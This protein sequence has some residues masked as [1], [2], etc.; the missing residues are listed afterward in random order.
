MN[1]VININI[2]GMIFHIDE[3]AFV[4]LDRYLE[5]LKQHF[6]NN[7]GGG[8]IL[9]DIEARIA[10]MLTEMIKDKGEVVS[11]ANVQQV[12]AT[13]GKPEDME[14]ADSGSGSKS[15][16][17]SWRNDYSFSPG[18]RMYRD[19]DN[20]IIGGVC[21]GMGEYLGIDPVWL[22]L[23]FCALFFGFGTG[24]LIYIILWI[25]LPAANTPSEKLEMR[26]ERVNISNIEKTVTENLDALKQRIDK[27][28]GKFEKKDF[29]SKLNN[30]FHGLFEGL[31]GGLRGVFHAFA[32]LFSIIFILISA[33]VIIALLSV[34][35][36]LT[37]I[38]G[39]GIP[40]F[41]LDFFHDARTASIVFILIL[42]LIGLPFIGLMFR[43]LRYMSGYRGRHRNGFL[44]FIWVLAFIAILALVFGN[45]SGFRSSYSYT[46]S[47]ILKK[48]AH[49]TLYLNANGYASEIKEFHGNGW[50]DVSRLWDR[51]QNANDTSRIGLVSLDIT[52]SDD[53]N[54]KLEKKFKSRGNSV[55]SA[56]S[57]SET[58]KYSYTQ[59]D[60]LLLF[61]E[62]FRIPKDEKWHG[63]NVHLE[64]QI[65]EGT[66]I[67]MRRNMN[68]IIYDIDNVQDMDDEEMPSH[69]WMMK[70]DGLTCLDCG[71]DQ[72]DW[73]KNPVRHHQQHQIH[74]QHR[75]RWE[76]KWND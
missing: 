21:S 17:Y 66:V 35:F 53:N 70:Q 50:M 56:M 3:E 54:I 74:Q 71:S 7:E 12:I 39:F 4:V 14:D 48:P 59:A 64:L 1:K 73:N 41:F 38:V 47:D 18:K 8:E 13:M 24:L 42:V 58:I 11:M 5:S 20:K 15:K 57:S 16:A 32:W 23:L 65:P 76:W 61:N 29:G 6:R 49:D 72:H 2:N 27:E 52:R 44:S 43:S 33:G 63:Q 9:A 46:T 28:F 67:K 68:D 45:S 22:R 25:I 30:F 19:T 40:V 10:E 26:G 51:I 69:V 60:S 62:T 75:G 31:E 34:V 55:R 36:G 37:G